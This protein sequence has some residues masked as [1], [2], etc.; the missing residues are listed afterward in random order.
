M[1][2]KEYEISCLAGSHVASTYGATDMK[3]VNSPLERSERFGMWIMIFVL[4]NS[5]RE[6]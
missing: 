3:E 2:G 4:P 6:M 1:S 5:E